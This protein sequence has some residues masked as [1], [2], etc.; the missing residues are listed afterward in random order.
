MR[1]IWWLRQGG[2]RR[3]EIKVGGERSEKRKRKRNCDKRR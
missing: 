3:K 2:K 1:V